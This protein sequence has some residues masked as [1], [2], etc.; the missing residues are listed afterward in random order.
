MAELR[1]FIIQAVSSII[2]STVFLSGITN[3]Y[4]EFYNQP[5]LVIDI[6]PNNNEDYRSVTIN[7]TNNGVESFVDY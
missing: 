4:Y 5:K 3:Y 1:V 2:A 7:V 6:T